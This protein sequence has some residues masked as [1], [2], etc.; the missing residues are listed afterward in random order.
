MRRLRIIGIGIGVFAGA[1]VL[2]CAT[3]PKA[4]PPT[5]SDT[6]PTASAGASTESTQPGHE[7]TIGVPVPDLDAAVAWYSKLLGRELESI[8]PMEG[9]VELRVASG[10]WLQLFSVEAEGFRPTTTILRFKTPNIGDEAARLDAAGIQVGEVTRI[11]E[12][13]AFAEFV[14]PYGNPVSLYEVSGE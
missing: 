1:C 12:V 13:V 10:T 9:I 3:R 7:V 14:D 4:T 11:P 2:G 6:A 8:E 5:P